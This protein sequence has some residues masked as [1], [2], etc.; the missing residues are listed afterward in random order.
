MSPD[1]PVLRTVA[2]RHFTTMLRYRRVPSRASTCH[3]VVPRPPKSLN[4]VLRAWR[5]PIWLMGLASMPFPQS[6]HRVLNRDHS[7]RAE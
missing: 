1:L 7:S 5:S 2:L 4:E 3:C 6:F